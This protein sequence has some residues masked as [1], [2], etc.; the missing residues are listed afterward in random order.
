MS[1]IQSDSFVITFPHGIKKRL[2]SGIGVSQ[3]IQDITRGDDG[4]AAWDKN[5]IRILQVIRFRCGCSAFYDDKD[6]VCP[7][8]HKAEVLNPFEFMRPGFHR[9]AT[10]LE[11]FGNIRLAS[12]EFRVEGKDKATIGKVGQ[13]KACFLS[14][15]IVLR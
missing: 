3:S 8:S 13:P 12:A 15:G 6:L 9:E 2:K 10:R 5:E 4:V 14:E 7:Q 11:K 1:F